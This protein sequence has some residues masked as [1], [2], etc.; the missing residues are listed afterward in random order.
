MPRFR[1]I[2]P[3]DCHKRRVTRV[4][5]T[6]GHQI[7][8]EGFFLFVMILRN[9][10]AIWNSW[11]SGVADDALNLSTRKVNRCSPEMTLAQWPW[12]GADSTQ[13]STTGSGLCRFFNVS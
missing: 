8:D 10:K 3:R 2:F 5:G 9:T 4:D 7:L 11:R 12:S 6:K 13:P 1:Y